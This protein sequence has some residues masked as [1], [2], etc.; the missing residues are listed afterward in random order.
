MK[1]F[2]LGSVHEKNGQ[3][4]HIYTST[5]PVCIFEPKIGLLGLTLIE[6]NYERAGLMNNKAKHYIDHFSKRKHIDTPCGREAQ[7]S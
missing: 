2:F 1:L 4:S 6:I 5:K 3:H 7:G